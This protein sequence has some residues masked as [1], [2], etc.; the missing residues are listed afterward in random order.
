[1]TS[2]NDV[3]LPE[4]LDCSD[5]GELVDIGTN[6]G[7][8]QFRADQ[9]EVIERARRVGVG[10]MVV[11]GTSLDSSRDALE[12]AQGYPGV[13]YSTAGV[14]PHDASVFDAKT[15]PALRELAESPEVVAIG[16]C[17][18]DFDRNFSP[19]EKQIRALERQI[20]LAVETGLPLYLHDRDASD[21]LIERLRPA[22]ADLSSVVVHCFTASGEV[23]DAYLELDVHIGVTGWI[24]DERRGGEL[25]KQVPRIPAERL[26][27]E[28]DAP[29][30]L[31]RTMEKRKSRR[32]EP[33]F[34][35]WVLQTVAE[36]RGETPSLVARQTTQN[37]A[38]FFK[39]S[40]GLA[41]D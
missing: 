29:Y 19:P 27:I 13:L 8:K 38:R 23:L 21:A 28:T 40:G 9:S 39:L 31:P 2:S 33:A 4:G 3:P 12:L 14:H 15:R 5:W 37:A 18:L 11:L 32:N 7:S 35:P 22:R 26:M 41:P 30:L 36:V 34:L 20:E 17:G 10:R 1:M 25:R 24:C 6:L 16:E